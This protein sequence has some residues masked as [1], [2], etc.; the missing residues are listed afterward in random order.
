LSLHPWWQPSLQEATTLSTGK[1]DDV[2]IPESQQWHTTSAFYPFRLPETQI[3]QI[4]YITYYAQL[5]FTPQFNIGSRATS[6]DDL[7]NKDNV[8]QEINLFNLSYFFGGGIEYN[9]GGQTSL[10]TGI[11]FNNGF[12]DVFSSSK[13]KAVLNYFTFRIGMMF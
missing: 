10:I 11:F 13:H 3:E 5:G 1:E 9:I 7:L 4:G 12:L 2:I 8:S 6:T